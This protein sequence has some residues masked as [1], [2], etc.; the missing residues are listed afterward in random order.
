[1]NLVLKNFYI[2]NIYNYK[3]MKMLLYYNKIHYSFKNY[4]L[5]INDYNVIHIVYL[6]NEN[7]SENQTC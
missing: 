1:M 4:L 7:I 3:D 6:L 5:H 2:F